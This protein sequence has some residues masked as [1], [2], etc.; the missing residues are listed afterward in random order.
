M[1]TASEVQEQLFLLLKKATK[2]KVW[3]SNINDSVAAATLLVVTVA[4]VVVVVRYWSDYVVVKLW[5][6]T[7][8]ISSR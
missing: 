5:I 7:Y 1:R 6:S 3:I 8:I 4:A 2:C